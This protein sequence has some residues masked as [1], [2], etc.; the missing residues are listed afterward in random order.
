M[1]ATKK[2]KRREK[3]FHSKEFPLL[4]IYGSEF[5]PYP[6]LGRF[7]VNVPIRKANFLTSRPHRPRGFSWEIQIRRRGSSMT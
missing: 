2:K 6:H 5:D 3:N 7:G 4:M 1:A